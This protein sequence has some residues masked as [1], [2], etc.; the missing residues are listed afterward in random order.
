[1]K[2]SEI[3]AIR[4]ATGFNPP[5]SQAAFAQ[6]IGIPASTLKASEQ[7]TRKPSGA[8][9]TLLKLFQVHPEIVEELVT[10]KETK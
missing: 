3:Q 10:K 6:V 1:M 4:A 7:G 8:A 2:L 5:L 9:E